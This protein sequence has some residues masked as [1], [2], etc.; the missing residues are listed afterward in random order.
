MAKQSDNDDFSPDDLISRVV[1]GETGAFEDIVRR[2]ERPLRAWLA[3]QAPPAVDVDELA[4]R[5]FVI[6]FQSC[7]SFGP[8]QTLLR[9]YS[10]LAD[11][12]C[13]QN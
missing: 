3:T 13:R 5:T 6:A 2:F 12:N 11:S 7:P 9:G 4:Q 8:A 10:R 1:G